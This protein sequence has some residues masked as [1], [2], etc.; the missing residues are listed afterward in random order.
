MDWQL[1]ASYFTVKSTDSFYSVEGKHS[2]LDD[3]AH[4]EPHHL[5]LDCF[6]A[7]LVQT[8][9][10]PWIPGIPPKIHGLSAALN[11][12]INSQISLEIFD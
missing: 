5:D 6:G 9:T 7:L 8:N 11:S 2:A 3:V 1:I 10:F 4:Y 12:R